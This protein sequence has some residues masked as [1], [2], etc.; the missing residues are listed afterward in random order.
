M[1]TLLST[2]VEDMARVCV[3]GEFWALVLGSDS[4]V[5]GVGDGSPGPASLVQ[6]EIYFPNL[7]TKDE[8]E[9]T[10]PPDPEAISTSLLAPSL[11]SISSER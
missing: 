3:G 1:N 10:P 9:V 6:G 11:S 2:G 8:C 4:G 5:V 7:G